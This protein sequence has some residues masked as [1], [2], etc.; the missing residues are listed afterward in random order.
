MAI[1]DP[2]GEKIILANFILGEYGLIK[3]LEK[4]GKNMLDTFN[5]TY[6]NGVRKFLS[7]NNVY[8]FIRFYNEID[9]NEKYFHE[10][11]LGDQKQKIRFDIDINDK[12]EDYETQKMLNEMIQNIIIN[13]QLYFKINLSPEYDIC[14]YHSNGENK[15]SY[16]IIIN[17]YC[18]KNNTSVKKFCEN[19]TKLMD[20]KYM[21][22]IDMEIYK[23]KQNFRILYSKKNNSTRVKILLDKWNYNDVQIVHK[24]KETPIDNDHKFAIIMKESFITCCENCEILDYYVE[25]KEYKKSLPIDDKKL[26]NYLKILDKKFDNDFPFSLLKI[27][28]NN[29]Y[30]FSR[31]KPSFCPICKRIHDNDNAFIT[32]KNNEIKFYCRRNYK[33]YISLDNLELLEEKCK[34]KKI[35]SEKKIDMLKKTHTIDIGKDN[36]LNKFIKDQMID[37]LFTNN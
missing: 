25:K 26:D 5:V 4:C 19:V 23:S 33:N 11:I 20:E 6:E 30:I 32:N 2:Y 13:F 21:K 28:D 22:Y 8:N 17:N 1:F 7:F 16:H 37:N 29:N 12:I 24:S 31:I 18:M 9:N 10:I 27:D 3:K 35:T 15:I 14:I 34:M 36:F